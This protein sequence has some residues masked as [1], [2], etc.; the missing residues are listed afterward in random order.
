MVLEMPPGEGLLY[1]SAQLSGKKDRM[2]DYD[3]DDNPENYDEDDDEYWD[4]D[5]Y[6][7]YDNDY[8]REAAFWRGYRQGWNNRLSP[9][10]RATELRARFSRWWSDNFTRCPG[11]HRRRKNCN[12]IPF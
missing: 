8:D 6:D 12:C 10:H 2:L 1:L 9:R 7:N 4:D 11:C 3:I 5:D